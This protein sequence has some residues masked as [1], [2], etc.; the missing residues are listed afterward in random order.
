MR[1][2]LRLWRSW[3]SPSRA[4]RNSNSSSLVPSMSTA[5]TAITSP[6]CCFNAL[7]TLPMVPWPMTSPFT[8]E[9]ASPRTAS[10]ALCVMS[11]VAD[12]IASGESVSETTRV[13]PRPWLV[14]PNALTSPRMPDLPASSPGS[15]GRIRVSRLE[16]NR[17]APHAFSLHGP[18]SGSAGG[19]N[20]LRLDDKGSSFSPI[21]GIIPGSSGGSV[22]SGSFKVVT[23]ALLAGAAASA[24]KATG[25]SGGNDSGGNLRVAPNAS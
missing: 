16:E 22:S 12:A 25:A 13:P 14:L 7:N 17:S 23:E 21:S 8:Q 5:F 10:S 24:G 4:L 1:G 18:K 15:A 20:V 9:K 2:C 19:A 3:S 11:N 6:V